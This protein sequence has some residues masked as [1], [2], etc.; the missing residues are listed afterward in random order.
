MGNMEALEFLPKENLD[1]HSSSEKTVWVCSARINDLS[2]VCVL[3]PPTPATAAQLRP[4]NECR[5]NL[6]SCRLESWS[7]PL[8]LAL[9]AGVT[10]LP[11]KVH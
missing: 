1:I 8:G 10:P 7:C 2:G 11:G 3:P 6:C 5:R 4:I 9:S